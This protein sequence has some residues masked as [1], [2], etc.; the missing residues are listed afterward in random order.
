MNDL[1]EQW[2]IFIHS[3]GSTSS[4]QKLFDE[5]WRKYHKRILF[6][7][8]NML[9]E[10]A[11]DAL[12][13][14]MLNVY[15]NLDRYNPLYSFSTWIYTIARNYC[16]NYHNK[17][18]L[19][20]TRIQDWTET[21]NDFSHSDTSVDQILKN[22]LHQQIDRV[23]AS[24]DHDLRQMAFLRFYDGKKCREI[25]KIMDIPSGTVKSRLYKIRCKLKSELEKYNEA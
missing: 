22:E 2:Y 4:R 6:F 5:I 20:L 1:V 23:L 9:N 7:I 16:I 3:R 13:E 24:F 18:K 19:P 10:D 12:Q 17:R 15:K 25:A 11:E 21:V 8:R 14:V